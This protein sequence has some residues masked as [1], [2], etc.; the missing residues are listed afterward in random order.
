MPLRPLWRSPSREGRHG[1]TR[2]SSGICAPAIRSSER[3][4][5]LGRFAFLHGRAGVRMSWR[6]HTRELPSVQQ[7]R[8]NTHVARWLDLQ[9]HS[10]ERGHGRRAAG[11]GVGAAGGRLGPQPHVHPRL[12]EEYEVLDGSLDVL[13]GSEWR[14]LTASDAASVPPGTA[15]TFRVGAGPVRVRNMHRPALTSSPISS[16]CAARRTTGPRGPEQYPR[17]SLHRCPRGRVSAAL[18]S[19]GASSE[20]SRACAGSPGAPSRTPNNLTGCRGQPALAS[21]NERAP[22]LR[23]V[24]A[25]TSTSRGDPFRGQALSLARGTS[26]GTELSESE[27]NPS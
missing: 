25:L 7:G 13:L 3:F 17:A 20:R 23:S 4:P 6:S 12:T 24:P 8:P 9:D 2:T 15:H 22:R 14:A 19:T 26:R 11:D 10:L 21:R 18:T 16:A 1:R 5:G 27:G